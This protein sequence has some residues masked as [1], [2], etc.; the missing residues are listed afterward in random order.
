[1][2]IAAW[3]KDDKDSEGVRNSQHGVMLY[4]KCGM[5]ALQLHCFDLNPGFAI[6]LAL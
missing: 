3:P 2:Q 6:L 1:M 4:F 5:L